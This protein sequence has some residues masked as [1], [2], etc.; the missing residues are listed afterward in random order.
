MVLNLQ[1]DHISYSISVE[2]ASDATAKGRQPTAQLQF[3]LV[4]ADERQDINIEFSH[5]EL[6]EFYKKLETVQGQLDALRWSN[7]CLE[8]VNN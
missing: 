8:S 4:S 1:L 5:A 6:Y 7:H 2:T 3:G